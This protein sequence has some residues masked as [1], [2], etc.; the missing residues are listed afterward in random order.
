MPLGYFIS[1]CILIAL[2]SGYYMVERGLEYVDWPT[3]NR[4]EES[5]YYEGPGYSSGRKGRAAVKGKYGKNSKAKYTS[6]VEIKE[7]NVGRRGYDEK[8]D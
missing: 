4:P 5:M 2:A 8:R 1:L 7:G 3:L 6:Q